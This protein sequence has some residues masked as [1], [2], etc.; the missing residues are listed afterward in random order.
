MGRRESAV[1]ASTKELEALALWL[2][3]QRERLQLTYAVMATKT[4]YSDSMLSRAASGTTVPSEEIVEQY[5][6]A[7]DADVA[8]AKKLWKAARWAEQDRRRQE[9]V[10]NGYEGVITRLDN[11]LAVR[12]ELISDFA[13]LRRAMVELRAKGGQPSLALLQEKAG[14]TEAGRHQL[15]KSTLSAVLR[16]EALPNRRHVVA[17]VRAMGVTASR[18][19]RWE[20]A[21]ERAEQAAIGPPVKRSARWQALVADRRSDS[22]RFLTTAASALDLRPG[23]GPETGPAPERGAEVRPPGGLRQADVDFVRSHLIAQPTNYDFLQGLLGPEEAH[24]PAG[25]TRA[26][27]PIRV[28][29]VYQR[30]APIDPFF[31][32]GPA[33][34]A[35]WFTTALSRARDIAGLPADRT[36][37]HHPGAARAVLLNL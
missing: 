7:C 10:E 8:H 26:G 28:P 21:W 1:T 16:G 30:T 9:R 36:A 20:K 14:L 15:P 19:A 5:A 33:G 31:Q 22:F 2:R 23:P 37:A 34:A 32:T 27:L 18:A 25:R 29:K 11:Q 35:S 24:P 17:F 3:A 13:Q 6:K 12:P 4:D